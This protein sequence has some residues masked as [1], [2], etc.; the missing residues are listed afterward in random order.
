MT[1]KKTKPKYNSQQNI[2]KNVIYTKTYQVSTKVF[3]ICWEFYVRVKSKSGH[4]S[5]GENRKQLSWPNA[6]P[7]GASRKVEFPKLTWQEIAKI[8]KYNLN[9]IVRHLRTAVVST[10][11]CKVQSSIFQHYSPFQTNSLK[12]DGRHR[13]PNV[14]TIYVPHFKPCTICRRPLAI[15]D[16]W[17][18]RELRNHLA[19][20]CWPKNSL[21]VKC[22]PMQSLI[23]SPQT[24][25]S[26]IDRQ[27]RSG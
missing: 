18:S 1:A 23:Q 15:S 9:A 20:D 5:P 6:Q 24:L 22:P 4:P 17:I 19:C 26:A 7:L 2:D 11:I 12:S 3:V 10:S 14:L 25:W 21:I 16:P 8:K 13:F 27:E